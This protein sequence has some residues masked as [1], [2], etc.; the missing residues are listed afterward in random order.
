MASDQPSVEASLALL[1][2]S[3]DKRAAALQLVLAWQLSR[4]LGRPTESLAA[5]SASAQQ[6]FAGQ[7]KSVSPQQLV[8]TARSAGALALRVGES[9]ADNELRAKCFALARHCQGDA[10]RIERHL[11]W[12]GTP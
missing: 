6:L 7:A 1:V 5:I 4:A 8:T 12:C 10:A 11:L 2:D 9:C 3:D